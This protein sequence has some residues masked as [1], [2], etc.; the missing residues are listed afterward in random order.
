MRAIL[1]DENG[2]ELLKVSGRYIDH[3]PS[4]LKLLSDNA[5]YTIA[6]D[7]M[8]SKQ[9]GDT[10]LDPAVPGT[11][12]GFSHY[13]GLNDF[14][15]PNKLTSTGDSVKNSA[16]H[17]QVAQRLIDDPNLITT[18]ELVL[19]KQPASPNSPPQYTYVRYAG[20]NQLATRL[21][22]L[23]AQNQSFQAAG[24]LP[25][26]SLTLGGYTSEMLGYF[27]SLSAGASDDMTSAQTLYD[28]FKTR[29]DAITGVNLDEELANTVIFQNS[30]SA[31]ARIITVVNK[32]FE[33]LM[34]MV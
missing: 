33:D 9:L 25:S 32:L 13:F 26:I 28:G 29:S 15:V 31:S 18:G 17:L 4:Y 19:Q 8:D 3:E 22:A 2:V 7:E 12:W 11:N 30:Y 6:I 10:T 14:F 23:S 20:D 24:G 16:I 27:A 1:V 21:K 5:E 34:Q